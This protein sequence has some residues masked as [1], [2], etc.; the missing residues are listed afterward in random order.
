MTLCT[1]YYAV[2]A[3]FPAALYFFWKGSM[4]GRFGAWPWFRDRAPGSWVLGAGP[5]LSSDRL[6]QPHL[7]AATGYALPRAF[8]EFQGSAPPLGYA[9]PTW[10][11]ALG[12]KFPSSW[13]ATSGLVPR[14]GE[15]SS[16][17]GVAALALIAYAAAVHVRF[18]DASYWWACLVLLVV[19]SGG[20][21][22]TIAGYEITCRSLA[23]E[24]F[25]LFQMIRSASRFNL[26][27]AVIAGLVAASG[28]Q[29][30]LAHLPSRW[31]RGGP[32]RVGRSGRSSTWR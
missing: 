26:F 19:L 13:Y 14:I 6:Q 4:A 30:L 20:T 8:E 32:R 15:C 11:H 21:A 18:R 23:Q 3:V 22:W 24:R 28:L 1:A 31:S 17:L 27:A 29:H 5:S 16:Y 7:G 2:F 9:C 25:P 10:M 12:R